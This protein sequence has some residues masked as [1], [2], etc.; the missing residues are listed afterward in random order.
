MAANYM[1]PEHRQVLDQILT[2]V[3]NRAAE[4]L[5]VVAYPLGKNP[6][7]PTMETVRQSPLGRDLELIVAYI[8]GHQVER[9][10]ADEAIARVYRALYGQTMS[11]KGYKLPKDWQKTPFGELIG[12]A[13]AKM[14]PPKDLMGTAEVMR[15]FAIK[16]QTVYDWVDE[17]RLVAH[18]IRGTQMFY[19]PYILREVEKRARAKRGVEQLK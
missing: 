12:A 5:A 6:P 2:S 19:R 4:L 17:G 9:N 18:Y 7:P 15:A 1:T 3:T 11:Q 10:A 16:R 14:I 13:H 8:E